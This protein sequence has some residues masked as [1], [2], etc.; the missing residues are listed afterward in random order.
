MKQRL[1]SAL[2]G[3]WLA[4]IAPAQAA[5]VQDDTGRRVTLAQPAQRIVT[6]A[7]HATELVI[8]AGAA[9]RLVAIAT[10]PSDDRRLPA[11]PH[12]GGPGALDREAL[13][14]LQPDLVVGWQSGNRASDLDW[15]TRSAIAVYRSEPHTLHDVSAA[16][17]ALGEL[18]GT[19][20]SARAAGAAFDRTVLTA[21]T[22]M[23]PRPAYVLVW[24][25]PAITIGGRH[26]MNDVLRAG[27]FRNLFA[28]VPSGTFQIAPEALLAAGSA[29]RISLSPPF[30]NDR[31]RLLADRLSRPG[32]HL[33]EGVALLCALR[34]QQAAD[35]PSPPRVRDR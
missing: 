14:V 7:P 27:G 23:P 24:E 8:A 9:D 35:P 16:I 11:L 6:L 4:A 13:L 25:Q 29:T 28:T 33:A 17:R 5:S 10:G 19:A 2:T 32:P 22:R 15:L 12:V 18:S 3:I 20:Q 30:E 26:W 1:A 34:L 31:Q 21:C